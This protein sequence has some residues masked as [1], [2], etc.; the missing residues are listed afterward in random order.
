MT[1]LYLRKAA[2]CPSLRWYIMKNLAQGL[3]FKPSFLIFSD[4]SNRNLLSLF[5]LCFVVGD[6]Q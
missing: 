1:N 4:V 5:E 6:C 3:I 2:E